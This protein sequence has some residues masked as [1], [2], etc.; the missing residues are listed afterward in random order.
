MRKEWL[1]RSI[2]TTTSLYIINNYNKFTEY[3]ES[4][5]FKGKIKRRVNRNF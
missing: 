1:E 4:H 3:H 2:I 5:Y